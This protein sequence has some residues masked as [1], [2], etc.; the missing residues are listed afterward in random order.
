MITGIIFYNAMASKEIELQHTVDKLSNEIAENLFESIQILGQI[1]ALSERYYDGS[2][3]RWVSEKSSE[4]ARLLGLKKDMVFQIKVAG[5]LHDIG[6]VAF[7]DPALFRHPS[8]MSKADYKKYMDHP[9]IAYDILKNHKGFGVI[10]KIVLQHHERNDGS[11]FPNKLKVEDIHPGAQIIAVV[12][13][14]HNF[15]YKNTR[16]DRY[17]DTKN[18]TYTSTNQLLESTKDKHIGAVKYLNSKKGILF[19]KKLVDVFIALLELE[20]KDIDSKTI[21]RKA[22]NNIETGMVFAEDYKTS[23]GLLIASRG[24]VITAD[25]KKSLVKFAENGDIPLKILVLAS[26]QE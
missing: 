8:E 17:S 3:C 16:H 6:K 25:M 22:V 14:Y 24:E 1:A 21:A 5:L 18:V 12:D 23:Y 9:E 20:R 15:V 13:T 10:S 11:G 26:E 2:H 4:L 19:D 7:T